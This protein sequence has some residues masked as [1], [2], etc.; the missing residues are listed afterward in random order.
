MSVQRLSVRTPLLQVGGAIPARTR[1]VVGHPRHRN[2]PARRRLLRAA[3][4]RTDAS[5]DDGS[6]ERRTPRDDLGRVHGLGHRTPRR[7]APGDPAGQ[8]HRR[9]RSA[10][11]AAPRTHAQVRPVLAARR[12]ARATVT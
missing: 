7:C 11:D 5:G 12:V 3:A 4:P 6:G 8:P 2:P 1:G 9:P 10:P